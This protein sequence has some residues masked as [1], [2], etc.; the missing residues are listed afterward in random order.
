M[1]VIVHTLYN[2]NINMPIFSKVILSCMCV[3]EQMYNILDHRHQLGFISKLARDHRQQ[4]I[5][6]GH[7]CNQFY[8]IPGILGWSQLFNSCVHNYILEH[9]C[10]QK[11]IMCY[12]HNSLIDTSNGLQD[13][14]VRKTWKGCLCPHPKK[15]AQCL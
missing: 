11:F 15:D 7:G 9:I 13:S 4:P 6:D 12:P 8:A 2:I 3:L 1:T 14:K 5:D 10:N